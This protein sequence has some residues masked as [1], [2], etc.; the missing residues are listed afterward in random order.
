MLPNDVVVANAALSSFFR[1]LLISLA[2]SFRTIFRLI[3]KADISKEAFA[4]IAESRLCSDDGGD[5]GTGVAGFAPKSE[6]NGL[7]IREGTDVLFEGA[8]RPAGRGGS[9]GF[10][11]ACDRGGR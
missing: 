5:D 8:G 10:V 4:S 9:G 7:L 1:A 11:D 2:R 6:A 3:V